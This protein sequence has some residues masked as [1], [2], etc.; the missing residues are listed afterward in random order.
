MT[1]LRLRELRRPRRRFR[2]FDEPQKVNQAAIV[3]NKQLGEVLAYIAA[4]QQEQ[5]EG[6]SKK[7]P[8]RQG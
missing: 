3:E 4:R 1:R 7:A 6:R 2:N 8:R 5:T